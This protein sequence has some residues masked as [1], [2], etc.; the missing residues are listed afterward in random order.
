MGGMADH[1][2]RISSSP[3][4]LRVSDLAVRFTTGRRVVRALDG[5]S[6][7]V[8]RGESMGIVGESGC[9][10]STLA[11]AILRLAPVTTGSIEF[12]GQNLLSLRGAA[13][14]RMRPALQMVFQDPLASLNPHL[15]VESIIGEAAWVHGR[16]STRAALRAE[17]AH[18]LQR[19]GLAADDMRRYPHEFSGGQRQ[20]IAIARALILRPRLLICDEAVSALDVSI[21][22][23]VLELLAE[24]RSELGLTFLFI[25]H[26]LAV[27]RSFC[28]RVAVMYL[29]R[30]VEEAPAGELFDCPRHPYTRALIA[31]SFDPDIAPRRRELPVLG[32]PPDP[33]DPPSGCAFR[34]RCPLAVERCAAE[35]PVLSPGTPG[36]SAA[37]HFAWV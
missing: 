20:R 34:T 21:Q 15:T 17:V 18:W 1:G 16:V 9:G 32:E 7:E 25:A 6:L 22:A 36:H 13:L 26:S 8:R 4:I 27:V 37:C 10:K 33:A 28:S 19:V 2:S 23:Q 3:T 11:R 12:D 30:I 14:R 35:R 5:V 29:G 31:A 24:L